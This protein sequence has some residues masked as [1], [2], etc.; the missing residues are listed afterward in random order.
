MITRNAQLPR[1]ALS[2]VSIPCRPLVKWSNCQ[3]LHN[4]RRLSTISGEKADPHTYCKDFVREHDYGSFLVSPFWPKEAQ[5]G[6]FALK[7]FCVELAMV[8]DV[9]SSPMIG[10]MRMQ[11]WRYAVNEIPR[12]RPPRHPIM[13]ALHETSQRAH[14][15][16][17][18]LKRIIDARNWITRLI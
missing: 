9:T 8:Q 10:K 15:P 12:G 11:F 3:W 14:L 7:A 4:F 18:H 1:K 16:L 5:D 6:Y 13:L 2:S 17:Y